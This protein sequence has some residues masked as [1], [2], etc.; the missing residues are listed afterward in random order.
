MSIR[1]LM[2]ITNEDVKEDFFN[3]KDAVD[4][5]AVK[6]GILD[7]TTSYLYAMSYKKVAETL[8]I[9]TFDDIDIFLWRKKLFKTTLE[10]KVV[11]PLEIV[12][13]GIYMNG[14]IHT[15]P[16]QRT[17]V[18]DDDTQ[19]YQLHCPLPFGISSHVP[20]HTIQ[21]ASSISCVVVDKVREIRIDDD[22]FE[23]TPLCYVKTFDVRTSLMQVH[24]KR[25]MSPKAPTRTG[26]MVTIST[27]AALLYN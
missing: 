3:L 15:S 22:G 24:H 18:D 19:H 7:L 2:I 4:E 16:R 12:R 1:H 20:S 23:N 17:I 5:H 13:E 26:K 25:S 9:H 11:E 10:V 14:L 21:F 27:S 6:I 8:S